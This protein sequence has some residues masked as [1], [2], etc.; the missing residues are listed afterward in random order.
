MV[1][2][3]ATFNSNS[4]EVPFVKGLDLEELSKE[5]SE[6]L[7]QFTERFNRH[8]KTCLGLHETKPP[9]ALPQPVRDG[10][11]MALKVSISR[12]II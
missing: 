1:S 11:A 3:G 5:L 4:E 10:W 6:E 7:E 12:E 2:K 8:A 9:S